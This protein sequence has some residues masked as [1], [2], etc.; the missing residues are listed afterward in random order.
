MQPCVTQ[1]STMMPSDVSNGS[2]TVAEKDDT[3]MTGKQEHN[4]I[5]IVASIVGHRH[6]TEDKTLFELRVQW[7]DSDLMTWE[8][9]SFIQEHAKDTFFKYWGTV[10]GGR[11]GAMVD[12][13]LWHPQKIKTHRRTNYGAVQLEVEWV[14]SR[15]TTWE[16]EKR[17]K[18]IAPGHLEEYWESKGGAQHQKDY[19]C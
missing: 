17:M 14:G 16:S 2:L 7:K 15:Q 6:K 13:N 10:E 3:D 18:K 19:A 1:A 9:E 8:P 5:G 12:K 4:Q 11:L